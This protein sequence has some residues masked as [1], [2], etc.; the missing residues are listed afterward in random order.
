[1]KKLILL[2]VIAIAANMVSAASFKW[3]AAQ[4]YASDGTT[5]YSGDITLYC[6]EVSGWSMATTAASGAV[7]AADTVFSSTSFVAGNDYSFYFVFEDGGKSFTSASVSASAQQS[8]TATINFGTQKAAT[9]NAD[10]WAAVPE[11]TS[12]LLMLLGVA[13]LALRRRR[14]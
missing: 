11:P 1:M 14:V 13:G 3:Q 5:L 12:G 4:I 9:Q 8:D 10:N 2:A 7:K 6:A